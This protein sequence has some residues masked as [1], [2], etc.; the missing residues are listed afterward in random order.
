MINQQ[1]L[2]RKLDTNQQGKTSKLGK[3]KTNKKQNKN[4]GGSPENAKTDRR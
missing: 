2:P 3:K 4:L 1:V